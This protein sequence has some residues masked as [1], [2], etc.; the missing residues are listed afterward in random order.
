[1][2]EILEPGES[3][4][5]S[6]AEQFQ[7]EL[8]D[9]MSGVPADL[10]TDP[11]VRLRYFNEVYGIHAAKEYAFRTMIKLMMRGS[12][13]ETIAQVFNIHIRTVYK[14]RK[15]Q[16]TLLLPEYCSLTL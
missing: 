8:D 14:W 12:R 10:P 1:V 5:Q 3:D 4:V 16:C 15:E 7:V 2:S 6:P 9:M 11:A 13:V